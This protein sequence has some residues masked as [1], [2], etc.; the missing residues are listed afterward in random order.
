V[1]LNDYVKFCFRAVRLFLN[2]TIKDWLIMTIFG[3]QR[4]EKT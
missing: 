2:N 3:M 4:Q 1:T